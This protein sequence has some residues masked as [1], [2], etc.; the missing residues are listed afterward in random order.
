MTKQTIKTGNSAN[1]GSGDPARTAFTKTNNNFTEIY[2]ALG[3]DTLP[4]ALPIGKGGTGATSAE[5]ARSNLG[6]GAAAT[7]NSIIKNG[8]QD[9]IDLSKV[10]I[11]TLATGRSWKDGNNTLPNEWGHMIFMGSHST[12]ETTSESRL[13]AIF[14]HDSLTKMYF[15]CGSGDIWG[16]K[17]WAEVWHTQNTAVDSNGFVKKA[18]PIVQLFSDKIELNDEATEQDIT[19]EKIDVGHYLIKGSSGFAQN[20]WYIET[21]K[22]ANGNILFAVN[23]QQ[24]ENGD[25]DVKTYKKKFDLESASIIADLQNPVDIPEGR[26]IDI[27]LQETPKPLSDMPTEEVNTD[28]PQQ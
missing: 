18:S 16:S 11:N 26:W 17:S 20:G 12:S 8:Y 23:Y 4:N 1:D 13:C 14:M 7:A 24:L 9:G 28:E 5:T 3:G 6:L 21:P 25:I 19:F 22:D 27:R 10:A 2:E 15:K